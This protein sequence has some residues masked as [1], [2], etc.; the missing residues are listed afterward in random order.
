M[1]AG[2]RGAGKTTFLWDLA[3]QRLPREVRALLP[4]GA[5]LW[6]QADAYEFPVWLPLLAKDAPPGEWINRIV[7]RYDLVCYNNGEHTPALLAFGAVDRLTAITIAP[8]LNRLALQ[9][10]SRTS[11]FRQSVLDEGRLPYIA[12]NQVARG[13]ITHIPEKG[14]VDRTVA[15]LDGSRRRLLELYSKPGWLEDLHTPLGD[16]AAQPLPRNDSRH[17]RDRTGRR[18]AGRRAGRLAG[19]A[20]LKNAAFGP[21]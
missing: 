15:E 14:D 21:G 16:R 11:R 8:R 9:C 1:V 20:G 10:G 7:L 13:L 19:K 17:C 5:H 12:R 4:P 18:G 2:A 6:P 3:E